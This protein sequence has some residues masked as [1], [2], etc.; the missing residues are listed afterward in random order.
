MSARVFTFI[1]RMIKQTD[2]VLKLVTVTLCSNLVGNWVKGRMVQPGE[3]SLNN[4]W[5]DA[6][7]CIIR[8]VRQWIKLQLDVKVSPPA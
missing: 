7:K 6:T 5:T 4:R 8:D 3:C 1:S 2:N